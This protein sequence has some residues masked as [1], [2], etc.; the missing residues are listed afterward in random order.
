MRWAEHIAHTGGM[1][2][3]HTILGRKLEEKK[4]LTIHRLRLED[5]IKTNLEYVRCCCM[6]WIQLVVASLEQGLVGYSTAFSV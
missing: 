4:L 6:D 2:N 3:K 5:N 1:K